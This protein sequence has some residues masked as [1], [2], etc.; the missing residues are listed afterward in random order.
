MPY[1]NKIVR[2]KWLNVLNLIEECGLRNPGELNFLLTMICRLYLRQH[3]Q[4]YQN[5]NAILGVLTAMQHEW[6]RRLTAPYED[7]KIE[8]HGDLEGW[9]L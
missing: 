1:V 7:V 8:E 9:E 4:G 2:S 3:G 5:H 6:Y